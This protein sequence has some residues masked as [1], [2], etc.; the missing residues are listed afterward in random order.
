[1]LKDYSKDEKFIHKIKKYLFVYFYALL[2]ET[3]R[4]FTQ[5]VLFKNYC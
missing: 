1:M 5:Y 3:L 4:N 2:F